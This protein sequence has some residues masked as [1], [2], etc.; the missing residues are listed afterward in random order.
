[1][2]MDEGRKRRLRDTGDGLEKK[3]VY[4]IFV[5]TDSVV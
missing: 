5:L 1:M 3:R 4:L 2:H